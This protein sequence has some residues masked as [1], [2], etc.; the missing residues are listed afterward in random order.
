VFRWQAPVPVFTVGKAAELRL[1][2]SGWERGTREP[3]DI[4]KGKAPLNA[5]LEELP[6]AGPFENGEFVYPLRIIPL[7]ETV[8]FEGFSFSWERVSLAV[9]SLTIRA[10]PGEAAPSG[11]PEPPPASPAPGPGP[12]HLPFPQ[13]HRPF[14]FF[15]VEYG[16]IVGE[17]EAL[18]EA[19]RRA[20]ALAEIRSKERESWAGPDLAALR[21]Q[22]EQSLGLGV[23]ENEKWRPLNLPVFLVFGLLL[24]A[25]AALLFRARFS[26]RFSA[27][28]SRKTGGYKGRIIAAATAVFAVILLI[29]LTGTRSGGRAVLEKTPVYRVPEKEGALNA[30]F[31]EG[32]PVNTGLSRGEWVYVESADGRAGWAPA[33]SVI[34]Y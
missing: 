31:G 21:R 29:E 32:Q 23:T 4:F 10:S 26:G 33:A 11:T 6:P 24:V 5:I 9:P 3:P 8:V 18:W 7:E 12:G 14:P 17:V 19:G 30:S 27:V 1:S 28:T 15:K 34:R 16:R 2:L 20:A 13:T 25:A 22:M